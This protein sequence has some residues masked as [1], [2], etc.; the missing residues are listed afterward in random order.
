[1]KL[2]HDEFTALLAKALDS[3]EKEASL[4]LEAWVDAVVRETEEN[5][6]CDVTGLGTFR[7]G[8]D[9]SMILEPEQSLSLEVNHKF[10]GMS[11][12]EVSPPTS[13]RPEAEEDAAADADP[14][15]SDPQKPDREDD[16]IR[17]EDDKIRDEDE[18]PGE[19]IPEDTEQEIPAS[20]TP[21]EP[22]D[23]HDPFGIKEYEEE[24]FPDDL[25]EELEPGASFEPDAESRSEEGK[26]EAE[27]EFESGRRPEYPEHE[28]DT[29]DESQFEYD[30]EGT[31]DPDEEKLGFDSEFDDE[32][33]AER[34]DEGDPDREPDAEREF[35]PVERD[36]YAAS[37]KPFTLPKLSLSQRMKP[38]KGASKNQSRNKSAKIMWLIPIAA[39]LIVAL[40]LYFHFDGQ[41]LSRTHL[42]DQAVVQD[43][44]P[45]PI[46]EEENDEEQVVQE[47]VPS[48]D[49]AEE[50]AP[51]PDMDVRPEPVEDVATEPADEVIRDLALP[52]GLMG[53]EEEVLIGAYTIV[54][55]SLRN[56]RKSEIEKQRLEN[57]G[58]KATRWSTVLP[59]G[60]TTYRVG[61]GQFKS[62]SD[63]ER[64]VEELPEPF[65]SNN[66]IIR[67]R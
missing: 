47:F 43:E 19:T 5:G 24:G 39:L 54:V 6:S 7:K 51:P 48:P 45:V 59:S 32:S 9:G 64:A 33:D 35:E 14:G 38:S 56:E 57:Q 23:E 1:M 28:K 53:P 49:P 63:A 2:N 40:L 60:I 18:I 67:I 31:S 22:A 12:I 27:P 52:Y 3:D 46:P 29:D 21:E 8:E 11:P 15:I 50:V 58:Y 26:D 41:R 42:G 62:V 44:I 61:I 34:G 36:D 66:F 17:D 37:D 30:P 13:V 10:A 65:R 20:D 25:E 16:K 55:H 4:A